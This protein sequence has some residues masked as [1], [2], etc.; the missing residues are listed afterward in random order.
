MSSSLVTIEFF[1]NI[2]ETIAD[3]SLR[4]NRA[5]GERSVVLIFKELRSIEKFNSFRNR[6]AGALKLADEE[7]IIT[8]TPDSV[9]F[10]FSGPEGDDFDKLECQFAISQDSDFERFMRFMHRYADAN[11][12][13]YGEPSQ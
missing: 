3:V 6:F 1:E 7:G 12:M 8:V 2:P 5:T 11:G 9:K 10:Y 13:A 4:R